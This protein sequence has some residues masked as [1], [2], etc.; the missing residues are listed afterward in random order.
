MRDN[1]LIHAG[2]HLQRS[3]IAGVFAAGLLVPATASAE[4]RVVDTEH[5]T[6][7]VHVFKS[8]LFRAFADNHVIQAPLR[9]GFLDDGPG[10]R[11]QI[12]VDAQRMRVLD[13]GLSPRDREQVQARMLGPEVLDA[14]RF[15]EIGFHSVTVQRLASDGWL[16]RGELTLHGQTHAVAVKVTAEHG[17]YKGSA[18]L[19]Q[20]DFGISPISIAGGTVKVKDE[21]RIDFD[22]AAGPSASAAR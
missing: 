14:G 16:V 10:P 5:S 21:V 19:K 9:N 1:S 3:L 6:L 17:R 20:T 13:P 18:P 7:T 15:P 2:R 8:G 11:V 22:I 12:L 4:I